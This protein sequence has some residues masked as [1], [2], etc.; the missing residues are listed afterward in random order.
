M[1]LTYRC[2]LNCKNCIGL[3]PYYKKPTEYKKED[4][5]KDIDRVSELFDFISVL[6][7]LGGEPLT[8]P[9]V[10]EII[11]YACQKENFKYVLIT[12]NGTIPLDKEKL[13]KLNKEKTIFS[14]SNYEAM[15]TKLLE[16]RE[17]LDEIGIMNIRVD[18]ENWKKV[19]VNIKNKLT[20]EQRQKNFESCFSK[21]CPGVVGGEIGRCGQQ[22]SMDLLEILPQNSS[23][24]VDIFDVTISEEELKQNI[25]N[26][27]YGEKPIK[28]CDYCSFLTE[29]GGEQV[30][31]AEQT[32]GK[33]PYKKYYE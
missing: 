15:S 27:I 13:K 8:H 24:C 21:N 2:S 9:D 12:T 1:V 19:T 31:V 18:M 6:N 11:D 32:K 7:L 26:L 23:E 3:I 5:F 22:K 28:P 25:K 4:I 17:I 20:E 14:F 16:S 30:P 29:P 33:L 10:Y